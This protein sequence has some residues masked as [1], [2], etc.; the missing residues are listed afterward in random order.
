MGTHSFFI[1]SQLR[2]FKK[3]KLLFVFQHF[4][5][6]ISSAW[7]LRYKNAA[8]AYRYFVIRK[9]HQ[10]VF[11][12]RLGIKDHGR[13]TYGSQCCHAHPKKDEADGGA[14]PPWGK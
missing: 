2:F 6:N 8:N 12:G 9:V 5:L 1:F 11:Q 14:Y 3:L 7:Y 13:T 10:Q 4:C